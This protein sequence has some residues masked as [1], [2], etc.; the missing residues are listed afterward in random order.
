MTTMPAWT[1]NRYWVELLC[2]DGETYG[3]AE[4]AETE[5]EAEELAR[6]TALH[7]GKKPVDLEYI[8]LE[9]S[10]WFEDDEA[11]RLGI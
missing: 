10:G 9:V 5:S 4:D 11:T 6:E 2:D 7:H 3:Y 8:H 1:L